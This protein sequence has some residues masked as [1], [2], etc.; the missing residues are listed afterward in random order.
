M[1]G[2]FHDVVGYLTDLLEEDQIFFCRVNGEDSESVRF[3]G[4]KIRQA[5]TIT[6][7][8]LM[9]QLVR[10]QK[11]VSGSA[12]L[13][14]DIA[15][16][17][18]ALRNLHGQLSGALDHVPD[19]PHRIYPDSI[20][21]QE[22]R[23]ESRLPD[24]SEILPEILAPESAFERVG[25]YMGGKVVEGVA[26]S[27]GL[28]RWYETNTFDLELSLCHGLSPRDRDRSVK[29]VWGGVEWD[30]SAFAAR[31]ERATTLAERLR[32][33]RVRLEPGEYRT[34]IAPIG[35]KG[36]M[37][38]LGWRGA[39]SYRA[40]KNGTSPFAALR[41]GRSLS[42]RVTM[43]ENHNLGWTPSFNP[44]GFDRPDRFDLMVKGVPQAPLVSPRTA[45]EFD[46]ESNGAA[47]GESPLSLE[48]EPGGLPEA[49]VLKTI[50]DGLYLDY[51]HYLNLSD[52]ESASFTGITRFAAFRVRGGELAEPVEIARFDDSV[53]DLLGPR[54][55]D[56]TQEVER[57]PEGRS[58]G[59]RILGG[60]SCPGAVVDGFRI[61]S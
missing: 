14:G 28:R 33:D 25:H 49:E 3:N 7:R 27:L 46:V 8:R 44:M 58:Y 51:L 26:T 61:V 35:W 53:L 4:G 50:G 19:D 15:Q 60:V 13:T 47:A 5:G 12:E 18:F 55:V 41:E 48:I 11:Q 22:S 16:D 39:F 37:R 32:A 1:Q 42:E 52:R 57:I 56:F 2:W 20:D 38:T 54:L 21:S 59:G 29:V 10:D 43:R 6:Q 23:E 45:R 9:L 34:Y 30:S 24:L 31:L 40:L 17:R 36:V